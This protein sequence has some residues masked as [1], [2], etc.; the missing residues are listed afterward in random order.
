M[1]PSPSPA[2]TFRCEHV[3]IIL[4][5][6]QCWVYLVELVILTVATDTNHDGYEQFLASIIQHDLTL[7][8]S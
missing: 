5:F 6:H 7:E 3:V 1:P 2:Q 8:V 4:D